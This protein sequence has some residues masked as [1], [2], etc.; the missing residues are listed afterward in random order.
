MRRSRRASNDPRSE[1]P[2]G[3]LASTRTRRCTSLDPLP[4]AVGKYRS[5]AYRAGSQRLLDE[6]RSI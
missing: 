1:P 5:A 4:Y 6:R 2:K 3:T